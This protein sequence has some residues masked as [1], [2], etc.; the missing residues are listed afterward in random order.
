MVLS[1]LVYVMF[2]FQ[3]LALYVLPRTGVVELR[4]LHAV[5]ALVLLWLGLTVARGAG[6]LWRPRS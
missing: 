4:A 6:R 1:A 3:F 5:N 2:A